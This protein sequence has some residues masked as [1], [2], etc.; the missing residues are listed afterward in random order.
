[1][2]YTDNPQIGN[3]LRHTFE[4]LALDAGLAPT[5]LQLLMGHDY[6]STTMI[7]ASLELGRVRE[8][9]VSASPINQLLSGNL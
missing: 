5:D 3:L 6:L 2:H 9:F 7:Y 4:T 8:R 1:L